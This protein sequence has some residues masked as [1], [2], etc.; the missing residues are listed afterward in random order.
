MQPRY[1]DRVRDW[2]K[3]CFGDSVD[4]DNQTRQVQLLEEVLE[5]LQAV[6]LSKDIV[7]Q[8]VELVYSKEK[9]DIYLET[10]DVI[11][12][13]AAFCTCHGLNMSHCGEKALEICIEN[14]EKI[15]QKQSSKPF[16]KGIN[17][18]ERNG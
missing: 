11:V 17:D 6:G 5:L 12:S 13:L 1:Q 14:T 9:G 2:T 3:K 10:G 4:L 7:A 8:M 18:V 15:R 16:H